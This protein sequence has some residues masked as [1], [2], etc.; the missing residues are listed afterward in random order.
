MK[1]FSY[2]N[3]VM[4]CTVKFAI[5]EK[6]LKLH[7]MFFSEHLLRM[8]SNSNQIH[9]TPQLKP[10]QIYGTDLC[11]RLQRFK[12]SSC[13]CAVTTSLLD[14]SRLLYK[15]SC[16]Y[17]SPQTFDVYLRHCKKTTVIPWADTYETFI[18]KDCEG[19]VL[20]KV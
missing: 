19:S 16:L 20:L 17:K 18:F 2:D 9:E 7:I 12:G 1:L 3:K 11:L 5:L 15:R 10:E 4:M 14:L 6:P 13:S 8:L